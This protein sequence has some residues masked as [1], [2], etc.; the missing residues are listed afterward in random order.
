MC[1]S[2]PV[3]PPGSISMVCPVR[4]S[5]MLVAW[6]NGPSDV[7]R[8]VALTPFSPAALSCA[9]AGPCQPPSTSTSAIPSVPNVL[10][11]IDVPPGSVPACTAVT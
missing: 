9:V 7:T 4:T 11:L 2:R 8:L 3:W 1:R 10:V 6:R 5:G